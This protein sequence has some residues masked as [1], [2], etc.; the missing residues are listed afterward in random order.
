MKR[1]KIK[2]S[3]VI[4][5]IILIAFAVVQIYPLVFRKRQT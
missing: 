3:T 4:L 5:Q 2:P 1:K